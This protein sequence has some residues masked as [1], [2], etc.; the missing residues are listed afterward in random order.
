MEKDF[1]KNLRVVG[2]LRSGGD[3]APEHVYALEGMVNRYLGAKFIC[4]ADRQL[5]CATIPLQH[6]WPGWWSKMEIFRLEPPI[7]YLDLDTIIR[8]HCFDILEA[9][10]EEHFV[11]LRDVYRGKNNPNAMQSSIIYWDRPMTWLYEQFVSEPVFNLPHGDQQFLEQHVRL[12][13][14]WQDFTPSIVSYKADV[15]PN[16]LQP[17]HKIVIFHG[18]PRP[19]EQNVI[20]YPA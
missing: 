8:G 15:V 12:A 16:G 10:R 20:P 6:N 5:S 19:W 13:E 7:L 3:Y 17:H 1:R 9:V 11:I 18:K 14:Y 4:L 2:V